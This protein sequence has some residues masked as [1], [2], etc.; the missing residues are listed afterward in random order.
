MNHDRKQGLAAAASLL[1]GGI[2]AAVIWKDGVNQIAMWFTGLGNHLREMSLAGGGSN[3]LA[4]LC[5]I[6]ISLLPAAG[7]IWKGRK[8]ADWLLLLSGIQLFAAMY[9]L[10]N[11]SLL[12]PEI[13]PLA[14][15][16]VA[17]SWAMVSF[18]CVIGTLFCWALLRITVQL[19]GQSAALLPRLL[20]WTAVIYAFLLG[21]RAV[22]ETVSAMAEVA[23]GNTDSARV[24]VSNWVLILL[25]GLKLIPNLLAVYVLLLGGKLAS[26][27]ET[28][29]F[30]EK[31]VSL[32][33][34]I[35]GK[36]IWIAKASLL[37]TVAEN[38]LQMLLFSKVAKIHIQIYIPLVTLVL[39]AVLTILCKYFRKAKD[40]NDDNAAII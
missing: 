28:A 33:E 39:C 32:A 1:L 17:K 15:D 6:A 14:G 30:E 37:L 2:T 11:P 24:S 10:V 7:L 5:V 31:T 23:A 13:F 9:F 18:G 27:L 40:V 25:A 34:Q 21:F 4:W 36:C 3:L 35:S 19:S 8:A 16:S 26:A 20:L 22:Q 29:P 12:M 38:L